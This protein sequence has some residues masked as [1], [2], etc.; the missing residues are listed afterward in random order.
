MSDHF[1]DAPHDPDNPDAGPLWGAPTQ[2]LKAGGPWPGDKNKYTPGVYEWR[3]G[4]GPRTKP[5]RVEFYEGEFREEP[6]PTI[7]NMKW[8]GKLIKRMLGAGWSP[9]QIHLALSDPVNI[10]GAC[11]RFES[12]RDETFLD[13]MI[14]GTNLEET[15]EP[16]T[17][18]S[19]GWGSNRRLDNEAWREV[20]NFKIHAEKAFEMLIWIRHNG[21]VSRNQAQRC[22]VIHS[23]A[24]MRYVDALVDAGMLTC[25]SERHLCSDNS[26][27]PA[28]VLRLAPPETGTAALDDPETPEADRRLWRVV[29]P[30]ES[31]SPVFAL[32]LDELLAPG[33]PPR[34]ASEGRLRKEPEI[35]PAPVS[36]AHLDGSTAP[37]ADLA[38]AAA[39]A[40]DLAPVPQTARLDL[41]ALLAEINGGHV[42]STAR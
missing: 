26:V 23:K 22:G 4:K 36:T 31:P 29:A 21:P 25:T 2:M 32:S 28:K 14:K 11:Y 18:Q 13:R 9:L 30:A 8:T 6:C 42:P 20:G 12:L 16:P 10:G 34:P 19:S 7:S 33:P 1:Y 35:G 39:A 15:K 41:D 37:R 17:T 27:R 38:S 5:R 40:A 24:A 3:R